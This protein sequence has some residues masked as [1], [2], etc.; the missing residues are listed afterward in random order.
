MLLVLALL[1]STA[2]GKLYPSREPAQGPANGVKPDVHSVVVGFA[3]QQLQAPYFAAMQV[4]AQGVS[5]RAKSPSILEFVTL[6]APGGQ[7]DALYLWN[8][9]TI[10]LV[11][12]LAR[13]PG[14]GNVTVMGAGVQPQSGEAAMVDTLQKLADLHKQGVL[15]DEEFAQQKAKLLGEK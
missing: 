15:T 10:N 12:E 8:Y 13:L 1:A 7:Y 14:V 2:C 11:N 3:Q 5:I 4:Q 9:A 6:Y